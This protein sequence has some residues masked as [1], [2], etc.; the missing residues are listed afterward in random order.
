LL[1]HT[2]RRHNHRITYAPD[3]IVSHGFDVEGLGFA[4]K[5]FGRGFDGVGVY[6]CDDEGVLRG[7]RLVKRLGPLAL[8]PLTARRVAIDGARLVRHRKEMGVP[9]T[10]LPFFMGVMLTTRA[11][12]LAGGLM[13][14]IDPRWRVRTRGV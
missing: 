4:K 2:L 12:E 1:Y 11:I 13:A 14:F 10:T 3:A 7:T 8:F 9:L 5:H 6:R